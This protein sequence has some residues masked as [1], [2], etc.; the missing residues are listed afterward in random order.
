M[1]RKHRS[2]INNGESGKRS[3]N[4]SPPPA[5]GEVNTMNRLPLDIVVTLMRREQV[6]DQYE[7]DQLA[8]LFGKHVKDSL[9]TEDVEYALACYLAKSKHNDVI[10]RNSVLEKVVRFMNQYGW[11]LSDDFRDYYKKYALFR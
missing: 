4:S 7:I 1:S 10:Y 2:S 9:S 6:L 8:A 11:H 5:R 3:R